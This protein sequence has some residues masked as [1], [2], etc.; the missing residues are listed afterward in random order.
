MKTQH[1]FDIIKAMKRCNYMKCNEILDPRQPFCSEHICRYCYGEKSDGY[2]I[3]KYL[4]KPIC[5]YC[6]L[7]DHRVSK[8]KKMVYLKNPPIIN[9]TRKIS[10]LDQFHYPSKL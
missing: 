3:G 10:V 2:K 1:K 9:F 4:G 6:Y 7:M 8:N 5:T